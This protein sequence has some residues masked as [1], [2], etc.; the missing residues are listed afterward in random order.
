VTPV[1]STT[2]TQAVQTNAIFERRRM[3]LD[4]GMLADAG[5]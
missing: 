2:D 3:R 5:G 1:L 4:E